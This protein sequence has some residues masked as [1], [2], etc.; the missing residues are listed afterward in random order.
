MLEEFDE[1]ARRLNL[2]PVEERA[3]RHGVVRAIVLRRHAALIAPKKVHTAPIDALAI[4]G[5]SEQ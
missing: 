3:L 2:E 4:L 5:R 1:A